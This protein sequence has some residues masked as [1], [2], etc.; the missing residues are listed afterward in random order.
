M[1]NRKKEN[2]STN[3]VFKNIHVSIFFSAT[4]QMAIADIYN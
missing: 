4:D 3:A 2:A 1:I